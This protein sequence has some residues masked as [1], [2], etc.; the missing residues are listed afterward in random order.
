MEKYD[1]IVIGAGPGGYETALEASGAYGMKV[2][3]VEKDRLGGTCLNRGCI[4]TKTLLHSTKLYGEIK[5]HG[6]EIGILNSDSIDFDLAKMQDRKDNVLTLLSSGIDS[7][8]KANK[9]DVFNGFASILDRNTVVI[10]T[11]AKEQIKLSTEK[12][13][14][15]TG[16]VPSV[17]PI[18]G[19]DNDGVITSDEILNLK[20]P[21][22]SL[23]IIGGGVIGCEFAS[24]FGAIGTKVTIIEAM[25]RLL[26]TM[27]KEISQNLKMIMK[28]SLGVDIHVKSTV[29]EI[30]KSENGL[31]CHYTEKDKP[32]LAESDLVLISIGRKANTD[33]LISE[34]SGNEIKS[35]PMEKGKISVD[36]NFQTGIPGIFAIG[37]VTGGIQLA[38]VAA[39]E[40]RCALAKMNG[41][42]SPVDM[43]TIPSCIYTSPEIA[44]VGMSQDEAKKQNIETASYKYTMGANGKSILSLQE[45]GFIKVVTEKESG[46]ILGAQMMCARATDMISQFSQAIVS[47]L[48][49]YDMGS[50]IYPHPTFSE[51]IGEVVKKEK[52]N[53]NRK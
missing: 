45:R 27:D 41:K 48:T 35:M 34:H 18:K 10:S 25:D 16:S 17:P 9:V 30:S 14:I 52:N 5:K 46:K 12:I 37:D 19:A 2:A 32:C 20:R 28:K 3:I 53:F 24:I 7:L 50:V 38:H 36:E 23:T 13:L 22:S 15:A 44:S 26:P 40:G 47:G 11:P 42:G 31:V 49:I 43:R 8:M 39:G 51:G 6:D 1:L 21:V 4:P 33:G 29:T